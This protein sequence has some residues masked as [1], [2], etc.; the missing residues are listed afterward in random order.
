VRIPEFPAEHEFETVI[1]SNREPRPLDAPDAP[2]PV[3]SLMKLLQSS[4]WTVNVGYSQAWR[5]G[6][7]TGTYRKADLFGVYGFDHESCIYR[8]AAIYWR[9]S[10][11]TEEFSWF[12]DVN[13][14]EQTEKACGTPGSWTWQD[15][16]IINGFTRHRVKVT[17]IKEFAKVRGSVLPGWFA[18]I[19]RRFA[20]QATK[21]LCGDLEEHP[22]HTWETNTGTAKSCSGKATKPKEIENV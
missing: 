3:V 5:K 2:G 12:R 11:K 4:G 7:R 15:G 18:G 10:D 14:I 19:A 9:F 21:A 1:V 17:D 8:I 20:E 16:R 22:S 13:G 6:Q